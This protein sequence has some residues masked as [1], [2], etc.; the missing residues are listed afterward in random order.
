VILTDVGIGALA[1]GLSLVM[2]WR[3]YLLIQIPVMWMAGV[4]GI[5]LF[6]VQHQ[7]DPSYW[8]HHEEWG[9][10]EAAL[11]GSSHYRL[12]AVLQWATG[13]I[14]IHHIHHLRPRIP[15]YNLKSC[16][17]SVPEVQLENPLT[18]RRSL[19]SLGMHLWDE[20]GGTLVGFGDLRKRRAS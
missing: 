13:S 5:W 1:F 10:I 19:G 14:G 3:T 15:N 20:A 17:A 11:Q 6:Y 8:A 16:L 7:F 4:M 9:S 18:I 12:P 2:G